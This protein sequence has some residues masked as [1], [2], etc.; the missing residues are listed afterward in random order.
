MKKL[1]C[2]I[3]CILSAITHR[4][5]QDLMLAR[6]ANLIGILYISEIS[7]SSLNSHQLTCRPYSTYYILLYTYMTQCDI[8]KVSDYLSIGI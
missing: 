5:S 4:L 6:I 3:Y 8:S 2:Y 7:I 1:C